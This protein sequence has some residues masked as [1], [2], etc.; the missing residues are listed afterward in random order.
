MV[1]TLAR[2]AICTGSL[3]A[4]VALGAGAVRA[5]N[6]PQNPMTPSTNDQQNP[7]NNP[8][9]AQPNSQANP[10]QSSMP[11]N[12]AKVFTDAQFV[13]RAAAG[14]MAEVKLGQLA[15]E[16]GSSDAVK[17][18]GQRMVTDHSDANDKLKSVASQENIA[19]PAGPNKHDQAVYDQLS[20]LSGSAFDQAYARAMVRDHKKTIAEFQQEASNGKDD[21][22]KGFA[23]QT[24]P[25]LRDHL[26]MAQDMLRNVGAA[27]TSNSGNQ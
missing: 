4:L 23:S 1:F 19:L 11:Q 5:Q 12:G 22:I 3:A 14:G 24:L 15:Q 13:R 21:A 18:F 6:N 7:G 8:D 10:D 26:K 16:K 9:T 25:T 17:M 2:K 20:N 27:N